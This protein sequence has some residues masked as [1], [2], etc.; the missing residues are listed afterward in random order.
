M[1]ATRNHKRDFLQRSQLVFVPLVVFSLLI[2]WR[3]VV[4]QNYETYRGRRWIDRV[5]AQR[6]QRDTIPAMR[7]NIFA[8]DGSL[9]A[10]SLPT[11]EVGIDPGFSREKYFQ[12]NIDSLGLI[13]NRIFREKSASDYANGL[14]LARQRGRRYVLLSSRRI[15]FSERAELLKWPFFRR[16]ARLS[17][18]GGILR[19]HYE[20]YHPFAPMANRTLGG[21]DPKTGRGQAGLEASFQPQLAGKPGVSLVQVL[22]GGVK[23]PLSDES[24]T[25]VEPGLDLYTTLDVNYQDMAE[26]ALRR[27]LTSYQAERGCV[28][29][30]EVNTGEIRAMANLT[31]VMRDTG[32]VYEENLNH[33]LAGLNDPGSTFKLAS[34]LALMQEKAVRLDQV[35]QTG[36]GV[37]RF[38]G[39]DVIDSNAETGGYGPLTVQQVFE[40]SSN[41]G[42][43]LL[44]QR[45]FGRRPGL[46]CQYLRRFHLTQPTGISMLGE[47]RPVVYNPDMKQ[48]SRWSLTSMSYGYEMSIA[49]IQMLAFYNAVANGGRWVRPII[50]RQ[51]KLANE[52]VEETLPWVD[53]VPIASPGAIANVKRM[54][55]GVVLHGTARNIQTP[56]YAIAGKTGTAQKIMRGQYV[57][58]HYYTSFIGYFPARQ[59]RYTCLV[60]IDHP[61]GDVANLLMAGSVSA[62]V[63]RAVADRIVAYDIGMHRLARTDSVSAAARRTPALLLGRAEDLR[64]IGQTLGFRS[65]PDAETGYVR[66]QNNRWT[67]QNTPRTRTPDVRGL[68]LRDA[69]PLLESRGYR[70]LATGAGKVARQSIPPGTDVSVG[71]MITLGL[72]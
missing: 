72:E 4:I 45:H 21:L 43:H 52:V 34:M 49:P 28:V 54:L 11:Y 64:T 2:V 58:K 71:K 10:T 13:L 14:R 51:V 39:L 53:P 57:Q 17:A 6:L 70:V 23:R 37:A 69:L 50:V 7:G 65:Q 1:P 19:V 20:R 29:V 35:V 38:K 25:R 5:E 15:N 63:F 33:A 48:W 12:A 47:G 60:M 32:A 67:E 56:A 22:A 30:M 18:R 44:V 26:S 66:R 40:K 16:S 9:L 59:P 36:N 61:R 42:V 68:P 46:Y 27:A 62:P 55:E 41:V 24:S 8:A 3:I 31:R